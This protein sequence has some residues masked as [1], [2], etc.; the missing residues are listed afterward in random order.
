MNG[1]ILAG[2]K[3]LLK[4]QDRAPPPSAWPPSQFAGLMTGS[5]HSP[6]DQCHGQ[7]E[8][9]SGAHETTCKD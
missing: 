1:P 3:K 9:G 6:L 2:G 7:T 8:V 5:D 4:I